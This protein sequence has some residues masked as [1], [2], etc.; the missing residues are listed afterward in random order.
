M[1]YSIAYAVVLYLIAYSAFAGEATV[2]CTAEAKDT[3]GKTITITA[4]RYHFGQAAD[5]LTSTVDAK[6]PDCTNT[7]KNLAPGDWY[8][9]AQSVSNGVE[10]A[11]SNIV[12]RTIVAAKAVAPVLE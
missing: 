10:G 1:K 8:F 7:F 4:V 9:M 5:K 12:K 6:A 2:K 11:Q 3:D